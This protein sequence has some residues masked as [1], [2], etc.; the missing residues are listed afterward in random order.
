[1]ARYYP[2]EVAHYT[3]I[4]EKARIHTFRHGPLPLELAVLLEGVV[5]TIA[6]EAFAR[7]PGTLVFRYSVR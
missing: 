3:E 6:N 7:S 2:A 4:A 5:A 1:V